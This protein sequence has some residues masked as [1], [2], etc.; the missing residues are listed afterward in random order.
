[1]LLYLDKSLAF[2]HSKLDAILGVRLAPEVAISSGFLILG[3]PEYK[4]HGNGTWA[5]IKLNLDD[6]GDVNSCQVALLSAIGLH[7]ERE[8]FCN[9]NSIREL[10]KG[11]F[12]QAT[13]HN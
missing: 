3:L 6:I 10:H 4:G 13:L 9:T 5:A 8:R 7:K 1:M 11:T 2:S 12:A